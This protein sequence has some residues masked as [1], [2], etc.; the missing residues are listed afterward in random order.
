M[1]FVMREVENLKRMD[2][3][4]IVHFYETFEDN[5]SVHVV[6]EYCVGEE[7]TKKV[8]VSEDE[9][10]YLMQK[11]LSTVSYLHKRFIVH[12]DLKL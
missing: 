4:N 12:R 1:G 9:A 8:R 2:H 11:I 6:M 5:N 10:A 3:P 7:M